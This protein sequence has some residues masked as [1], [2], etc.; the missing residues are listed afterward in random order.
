[1]IPFNDFAKTVTDAQVKNIYEKLKTPVKHGAVI[2]LPDDFTDSPT[3]FKKDGKYYMLYI[4]INKNCNNSGYETHLAVSDDLIHFD[5]VTKVFSRDSLNHWDSKQISGYIGYKDIR[6]E[7]TNEA[8]KINGNYYL[9][10]MGA[11]NDGYEP[12]PLFMGLAKTPDIL[13]ASRYERFLDPILRPDDADAREKERKTIYKGCLFKDEL[14]VT[15]YPYVNIYNA[16][17]EQNLERIFLAV[18][19]DG[20][21]FN[22]YGEKHILDMREIIPDNRITGDPQII[23]IDDIYV[24]L[25]FCFDGKTAYDTFACSLDLKNWNIWKD[26][27]L[28]K[29]QYE[30]ENRYAHKPWFLRENGVNYHYYCAVNTNNERFIALATSE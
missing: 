1:M 4:S 7:G 29:P 21:H 30:W 5:Y 11:N 27:P 25:F 24:M 2:K 13:D 8:Q 23:L 18:S 9:T 14:K 26:E 20:E 10:Y 28:I 6:F 3:V 12:D 15:G 19:T 17:D 16:K 22:R